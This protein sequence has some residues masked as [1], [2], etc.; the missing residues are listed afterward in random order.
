MPSME[1]QS[2]I[3]ETAHLVDDEITGA[4]NKAMNNNVGIREQ[5]TT[6]RQQMHDSVIKE[7]HCIL[8]TN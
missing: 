4:G 5:D 3:K 7:R 6:G 8:H 2:A 1:S